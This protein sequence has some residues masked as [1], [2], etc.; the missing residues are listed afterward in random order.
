MK[1]APSLFAL[2]KN[3][4]RNP[5]PLLLNR[6]SM[7]MQNDGSAQLLSCINKNLTRKGANRSVHTAGLVTSPEASSN[8]W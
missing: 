3:V 4:D 6:N 7:T 2:Y 8:I 5:V 1:R